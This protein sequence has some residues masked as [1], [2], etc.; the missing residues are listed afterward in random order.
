[1]K[2]KKKKM[3]RMVRK[4]NC[5]RT[6]GKDNMLTQ[7]GSSTKRRRESHHAADE[8]KK[9]VEGGGGGGQCLITF[10]CGEMHCFVGYR[11]IHLLNNKGEALGYASLF[12]HI[13]INSASKP[14]KNERSS[15]E[16]RAWC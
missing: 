9:R 7:N 15:F 10:H 5:K 4:N 1:M 12:V 14:P 16:V 8:K 13:E 3:H 2:R 11:H 6:I